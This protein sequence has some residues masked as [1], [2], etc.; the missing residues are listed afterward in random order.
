MT[1]NTT[2]LTIA[3]IIALV[4]AEFQFYAPALALLGGCI[5]M[6]FFTG[7]AKAWI[8]GEVQ[9]GKAAKGAM[10]KLLYLVGVVG[11]FAVDLLIQIAI[12]NAGITIETPM[13]FG[14]VITFM[15]IINELI[16]IFENLGESGVPIPDVV[17]KALHKLK[18]KIESK[19]ETSEA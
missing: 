4:C 14:I 3:S 16:S 1:L 18:G 2:K 10:I 19:E 13:I 17:M 7:V 6:D 9:S 5:L 11:G 15:L 8:K 12:H